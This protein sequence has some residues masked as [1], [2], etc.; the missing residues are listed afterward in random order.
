[1]RSNR[2]VNINAEEKQEK[3]E[4]LDIEQIDEDMDSQAHAILTSSQTRSQKLEALNKVVDNKRVYIAPSTHHSGGENV[5]LRIRHS[6]NAFFKHPKANNANN[7]NDFINNN[8]NLAEDRLTFNEV[9]QS[10]LNKKMKLKLMEQF[11]MTPDS[12]DA[13]TPSIKR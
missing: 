1:M 8:N 13:I 12:E 4:L 11:N 5:R 2:N 3:I 10:P 6:S 7:N 9:L